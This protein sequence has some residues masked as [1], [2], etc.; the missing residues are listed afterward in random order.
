MHPFP[1]LVLSLSTAV[2]VGQGSNAATNCCPLLGPVLPAPRSFNTDRDFQKVTRNAGRAANGLVQQLG[3]NDTAVSF[4]ARSIHYAKPFLSH[5]ITPQDVD[6]KGARNV[7][8]D[9][10]LRIGSVSRVFTILAILQAGVPLSD[11]VTKYLPE[12]L[13]LKGQSLEASL[14]IVTTIDW[15]RVSIDA[16]ISELAGISGQC[17]WTLK[18][19]S[20]TLWF[21]T[22]GKDIAKH[23][24]QCRAIWLASGANRRSCRLRWKCRT[25]SLHPGR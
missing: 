18:C 2:V 9:T 5:Q 16:P 7:T 10:I 22:V 3:L 25:K 8:E 12:L 15:R 20:F 21:R 11:P 13:H 23:P 24:R 17:K 14:N 19:S 1:F 4:A 6:P